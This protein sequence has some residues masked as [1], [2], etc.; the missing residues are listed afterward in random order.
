MYQT[1]LVRIFL[2]S[3][4]FFV[5]IFTVYPEKIYVLLAFLLPGL[6]IYLPTSEFKKKLIL[7]IVSGAIFSFSIIF[8]DQYLEREVEES[9]SNI[10]QTEE[11]IIEG[12]IAKEP[13]QK[14]GQ[15][16]IILDDLLK[17]GMS[18]KGKIQFKTYYPNEINYGDSIKASGLVVL[19]PELEDFRSDE[20]L[21][22]KGVYRLL[23]KPKIIE[24]KEG[25]K[26]V[27]SYIFK[28]KKIVLEQIRTILPEPHA[29]FLNGLL[30]GSKDGLPEDVL[31]NFRISGITHIIAISGYNITLIITITL[32]L[33]CFLPRKKRLIISAIFIFVFT[34]FVGAEASVVRASIMGL[35][36]LLALFTGRTSSISTTLLISAFFMVLFNY[37]VLIYD[38]GFQLS[39][40]ATIGLVYVSPLIEKYFQVVPEFFAIRESLILTLS[41][42]ITALP[43]ILYNFGNLSLVSPLAN[44]T[45]LPFI[46]ISMF[47]GFIACLLS[48]ISIKLATFVSLGAYLS[49]SSVLFISKTL[50]KIPFSEIQIPK[51]S[52]FVLVSYYLL[53]SYLIY[54]KKD[55]LKV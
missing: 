40:L 5:G 54:R 17:E 55:L 16:T 31:E 3:F 44:I 24:V 18:V 6:L 46:P 42:Q 10:S 48:F 53:I 9:Y 51:F 14:D 28:I 8:Y 25:P 13:S 4:L 19:P 23:D 30:F 41:A 49:M 38:V 20:Y 2:L 43:I 7:V 34:V 21:K 50:A 32:S 52:P 29:G 1:N 27:F 11:T 39:F 37:R 36:S 12:I 33:L 22:M 35:I 45:C 15:K 26:S 47:F